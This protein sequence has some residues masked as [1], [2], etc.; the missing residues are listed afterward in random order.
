MKRILIIIIIFALVIGA[1]IHYDT[2]KR[3]EI[4][5]SLELNDEHIKLY[6]SIIQNKKI[7]DS[8]KKAYRESYRT[9]LCWTTAEYIMYEEDYKDIIEED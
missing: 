1:Y 4:E 8:R 7:E 3:N 5:I 2:E 9:F 6:E